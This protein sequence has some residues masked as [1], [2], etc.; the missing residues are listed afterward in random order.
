MTETLRRRLARALHAVD[1]AAGRAVGRRQVLF[2][3]RLPMHFIVLHPIYR[4][5]EQD[6]RVDVWV[7]CDG[8]PDALASYE[9][10]RVMDRFVPR[11]H[12]AWR[13]FD[14]Y[15]NADPWYPAPLRRCATR[16]NF[17]HGVAG[18]YDLDR[19][20]PESGLFR[21]YDLVAFANLDRMRRYVEAGVI[22]AERASLVGYPKLDAL[23]NGAHDGPAVRRSLKLDEARPTV[24]YAPTWSPASSLH[25]A[26]EAIV[27][28][29]LA[30]RFNVIAKL[31]DNCFLPD[32]KY[33]AGIDWRERLARFK[34]PGFALVESH[35]STPYLAASDLLVTDHSS[36]GFEFLALDRPLVVFDAPELPRVARINPDKIV[37]LRSAAAVAHT[38][39]ELGDLVEAELRHPGRRSAIRRRVAGEMFH[40]PG[41]ATA[42][43]L[44]LIYDAIGLNAPGTLGA[45]NPSRVE[46]VPPSASMAGTGG[47]A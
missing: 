30:R 45:P 7:T 12:C 8:R 47:A 33:A 27:E 38:P 41:T 23:V 17:F 18:K 22:P 2:E 46:A 5:L 21:E 39:D 32:A 3:S 31:H 44:A 25:I 15:L 10:L 19:P 40:R 20:S 28:T 29:L 42:R 4:A 9:R 1:T 26:G 36:I 11:A 13:R 24:T 37:L 34:G 43:A 6:P 35:D 16:V 14:L